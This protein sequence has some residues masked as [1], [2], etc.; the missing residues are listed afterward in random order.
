MAVFFFDT[1]ALVKRHVNEVGSGWVRSHTAAKAGH[2]LYIA[3]ITAVE[4]TSASTRRQ[5]GGTLT[6]AQGAAIYGHF[7]RHL[8]QRYVVLDITP[9]LMAGA[10][11]LAGRTPSGLRLR[12]A[13]G[14]AGRAA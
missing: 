14:G 1:S 13:L 8:A 12:S 5:R 7:R 11:L 6:A 4:M 3:R 9:A 2:T 10:V